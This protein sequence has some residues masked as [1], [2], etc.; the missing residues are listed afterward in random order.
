MLTLVNSISLKDTDD[1]VKARSDGNL[2][3]NGGLPALN[4]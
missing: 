4:F 3:Y 1:K 2:P